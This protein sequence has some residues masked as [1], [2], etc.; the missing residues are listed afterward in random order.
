MRKLLVLLA[1]AALAACQ[2]V[3]P[4]PG[5]S[6]K[7]VAALT[8]EEF[9]PV[10]DNYELGLSDRVLFEVDKSELAPEAAERIG[11]LAGVLKS[12]DI[13]GAGVEGHTDSTGSGLYN[14]QL[15]ER[16]AATVKAE[17]VKAGMPEANVRAV[18]KG[19]AQPIASNDTDDG[20][21]QNRR[22]VIVVTPADAN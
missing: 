4:K 11:K 7:Q 10:G 17:F 14:Q 9:K 13:N 12:V 16:R 22:V 2:T 1:I 15:S 18:G 21:A 8:Q 5:F 6:A 20:R 19:E 3:P